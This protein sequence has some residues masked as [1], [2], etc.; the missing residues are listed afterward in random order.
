MKN[1]WGKKKGYR[2]KKKTVFVSFLLFFSAF[3]LTLG[4]LLSVKSTIVDMIQ[5]LASGDIPAH[6]KSIESNGDGT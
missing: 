5:F 6:S 1:S 2:L 4:G 3:L